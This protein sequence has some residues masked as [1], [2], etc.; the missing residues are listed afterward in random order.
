MN[1]QVYLTVSPYMCPEEEGELWIIEG[2]HKVLDEGLSMFREGEIFQKYVEDRKRSIAIHDHDM[3]RQPFWAGC[4]SRQLRSLEVYSMSPGN[5][6][7][8]VAVKHLL[9]KMGKAQTPTGAKE[10]LCEVNYIDS[11]VGLQEEMSFSSIH[12]KD[13]WT[14]KNYSAGTSSFGVTPWTAEELESSRLLSKEV[15]VVRDDLSTI[16]PLRD[17]KKGPA[18]NVILTTTFISLRMYRT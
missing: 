16:R 4:I 12:T 2:G 1:S 9:K 11:T 8:P 6:V 14:D 17:G 18:G 3:G 7:P 5:L 10:L 13:S 15:G